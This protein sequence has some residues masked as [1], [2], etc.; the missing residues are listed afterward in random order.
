MTKTINR[1]I[2][3]FTVSFV[4]TNCLSE[5]HFDKM[6]LDI[7][8]LASDKMQGRKVF[9][10]AI[11]KA[12]SYI[13]KRFKEIGLKPYNKNLTYKQNF[14]IHQVFQNS[15]SVILNGKAIDKSFY[16]TRTFQ[17][18]VSLSKKTDFQI[19]TVSE[20]DDFRK[21]VEEAN[22]SN[23]NTLLLVN[24]KHQ[25][26]FRR[27][28]SYFDRPSNRFEINEGPSLVIVITEK[29]EVKEIQ[30][31]IKNSVKTQRLTNVVGV[32]KANSNKISDEQTKNIIYSAHYDHLGTKELD[33]K[34][35]DDQTKQP[36]LIFNG[37][38]DDAS[39]VTA[40]INLASHFA[41]VKNRQRDLI[42][43]AFTAEEIGGFGSQYFSK[44]IN[45]NSII[46]MINIEM[47]GKPSKF[48]AGEFWMTGFERSNLAEILQKELDKKQQKLYAD[49]YP[50]Q[51]LFYRSDNATLARLGVPAHSF[52]SDQIDTDPH[53][54]KESDE[55]ESLNLDSMH[56]IIEKIA[57][58]TKPL[59]ISSIKPT[60]LDTSKIKKNGFYF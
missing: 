29:T 57:T 49:P 7:E 36:D 27:Y 56:K 8:T 6:K 54:H 51:Q 60:R 3:I 43:V 16:T 18:S 34:L 47:I 52:S 46:A 58:A 28:Q 41:N 44:T 31:Q 24:P 10:P 45:A 23:R 39:G 48:G 30:V 26:I 15:S 42:F 14:S 59:V 5:I 40:V 32:L 1:L 11:D 53:Y 21:S 55:V 4:S 35:A 38:D 20:K 19:K 13:E 9:T 37:A 50:K 12:A 25:P 22:H 33:S 2:L 17:T